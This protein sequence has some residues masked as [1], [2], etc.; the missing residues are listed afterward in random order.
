MLVVLVGVVVLVLVVLAGAGEERVL[1]ASSS[2][3]LVEDI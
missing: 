1:V 3:C 2:P